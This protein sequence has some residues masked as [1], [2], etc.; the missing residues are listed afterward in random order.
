MMPINVLPDKRIHSIDI[1]RALTI[2]LMVFVNEV[3]GMHDI[4]Q[5]LKH[6]P[7][8]ADAMTITDWVFPGFLF[9]VGMSI[10][11]AI[12]H[13]IRKG[14]SFWML[15]KHILTRTLGLLVLGFFMVNAESGYN[16]EAMLIPI[17]WWKFLFYPLVILT[18]NVYSF[19]NKK[20]EYA[21]RGLGLCGLLVL[22][23]CYRG[24]EN[25]EEFMKPQW[26]GILGLI[27]WAY[28]YGSI[29]YQLSK[30]KKI[31]LFVFF[32]LC[33]L[34]FV[35]AKIPISNNSVL[36]NWTKSQAGHAT[37][38]GIVL[39]GMVL[40]LIFFDQKN[41]ASLLNRYIIAGIFAFLLVLSGIMLRP[42]FYVSKIFATPSW[43]MFSSAA[44]IILFGLLHYV[45]DVRQINKW[46]NFFK[47]AGTNPLLTYI[48]PF[49][50]AS[51]FTLTNF[52]FLPD[53][54]RTGIYGI[55]F[56]AAYSVLVIWLVKLL[57]KFKIRLQL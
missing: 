9:I 26:W 40:S 47:P 1:L 55:L 19:K 32:V 35:V 8:G 15:Q 20:W 16:A 46:T 4:P 7:A 10:P 52:Y 17:S 24:G 6:M 30:G 23:L 49:I 37:H 18:W 29:M 31:A 27:G 48:V 50:I 56:S 54:F 38:T 28:L 44:S 11:F 25:G 13:R 12:N 43:A 41:K 22:A 53:S 42:A 33:T 36:L 2:L 57:N 45:T 3:A 5:W 34:V 21:L 14:D 39:C 51:V